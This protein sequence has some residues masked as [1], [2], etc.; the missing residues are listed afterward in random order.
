MGR[1]GRVSGRA[2]GPLVAALVVFALTLGGLGPAAGAQG[3]SSAWTPLG[4]AGTMASGA[5]SLLSANGSLYVGTDGAGVWS[6]DG[7]G[8]QSLGGLTGQDATVTAL[9]SSGSSLWAG[10]EAGRVWSWD[11]TTW[12]SLVGLRNAQDC[13]AVNVEAVTAVTSFNGNVYAGTDGSGLFAWNP[14]FSGTCSHQL[15][16]GSA[17]NWAPALSF[18]KEAGVAALA[19]SSSDLYAGGTTGIWSLPA[20]G[21]TWSQLPLPSGLA[22]SQFVVDSLAYAGST[23]YAGTSKSGVWTW[24][25]TAW[26]ELGSLTGYV[27]ALA[28]SNGQLFATAVGTG[29]DVWAWTGSTWTEVGS[30]VGS[31]YGVTTSVTTPPLVGTSSALYVGTATGV[32][33]LASPSSPSSGSPVLTALSQPAVPPGGT[34]VLSGSGFGASPGTVVFQ[35]GTNPPVDVVGSTSGWSDTSVT[36]AV[37]TT[38][39]PEGQAIAVSV[40]NAASGLAS[41]TLP[42]AIAQP[43]AS[44]DSLSLSPHPIATAGSLSPGQSVTVTA[45]ATDSSGDPVP[46]AEMYASFAQAGGGG[47]AVVSLGGDPLASGPIPV[48]ANAQGKVAFVYTAPP[49]PAAGTDTLTVASDATSSPAVSASDSYS[50]AWAQLAG[51]SGSAV[52]VNALFP[53]GSTLYAGTEDGVWAWDGSAWSAV[54]T[55]PSGG[56]V[57][58]VTGAGG[59][60]YAATLYG[61]GS[62]SEVWQWSAGQASWSELGSLGSELP[63]AAKIT[64]LLAQDGTLYAATTDGVWE[65]SLSS[66]PAGWAQV[67]AL[68]GTALAVTSLAAVGG[69][70]YAGTADQVYALSAGAWQT[71]GDLAATNAMGAAASHVLTLAAVNGA[72]TAGTDDGIWTLAGGSWSQQPLDICSVYTN[73]CEPVAAI[74]PWG[75]WVAVDVVNAGVWAW[76]GSAWSELTAGPSTYQMAGEQLT[77]LAVGENGTLYA[78]AS[79]PSPSQAA[80]GVYQWGTA[81]TA[82]G[83]T[84]PP[85][86][87]SILSST[88]PPAVANV[89]Y[90]VELPAE[91]GT[92]PYTW[93]LANAA[94]LPAG[95]TLSAGGLLSGTPTSAG[96]YS[97][98]VQVTDSATS[99]AT[100]TAN[101]SLDVLAEPEVPMPDLPPPS[102]TQGPGLTVAAT[103][104]VVPTGA[105]TLL[106]AELVGANGPVSGASVTFTTTGGTLS[107]ASA[108][109]DA[110]G[111]ARVFL[112]DSTAESDTVTAASGSQSGSARITFKTFAAPT[113]PLS[114]RFAATTLPD[115][116][117]AVSLSATPDGTDVVV[118]PPQGA[119]SFLSALRLMLGDLAG[120]SPQTAASDVTATVDA[121][122]AVESLLATAAD[123]AIATATSAELGAATFVGPVVA[124]QTQNAALASSVFNDQSTQTS[125]ALQV[126]LPFDAAALPAGATPQVVWLDTSTTPQTWTNV[127]VVTLGV[128]N[129]AGTVTALLPHLSTYTV[130]ATQ[131]VAITTASLPSGTVGAAYDASLAAQGGTAPYTWSLASGS[132]PPGL[133]LSAAGVLSGTPSAA[134]TYS[135]NVA[136]KDS[137]SPPESA[138]ATLV[139]TV[140]NRAAPGP[141]ATPTPPPSPAVPPQTATSAY[142]TVGPAGGA[143]LTTGDGTASL[144]VPQG[145]FAAQTQVTVDELAPSALPASLPSGIAPAGTAVRV[146]FGQ[147]G[148]VASAPLALTLNEQPSALPAPED[149]YDLEVLRLTNVGA[150]SVW[151]GV[152]TS[153]D[154][155]AQTVTAPVFIAGV[156]AVGAIARSAAVALPEG[157]VAPNVAQGRTQSVWVTVTNVAGERESLRLVAAGLASV[158]GPAYGAVRF[159]SVRPGTVTL[160]PGASA[161][162][163]LRYAAGPKAAA[164]TYTVYLETVVSG[165][166]AHGLAGVSR[167]AVAVAVTAPA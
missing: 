31:N 77:A 29:G 121:T 151:L 136:V 150:K 98:G 164:G 161:R 87:L 123:V 74:V 80:S 6:W 43:L 90:A 127:G 149:L 36:V 99:P 160:P 59:T 78:A 84:T 130:V 46:Y 138:S 102:V 116:A 60:L 33:T 126:T 11:G 42:I 18:T 72:L 69:T 146:T 39:L 64:S 143:T 32:L 68:S 71:V 132:L 65:T 49:A 52:F 61:G 166:V 145:A 120:L 63:P 41:N 147:S 57:T 159:A 100:A 91:G 13:A 67:G 109:T 26:S 37:P 75:Q 163:L 108:T 89:P 92:A 117:N 115:V 51:L 5:L 56:G 152:P 119:P 2:R 155:R 73:P 4:G 21:T 142:A 34:L 110:D 40:E 12:T 55:G 94:S 154:A 85:A 53:L 148:A 27:T 20:N 35:Q 114:G 133:A 167:T 16:V 76:D 112:S 45:S 131:P 1:L 15:G 54:G 3:G 95:L 101:L 62:G 111:V 122:S 7:S 58:A 82:T 157:E 48:V 135:L 107:A 118:S 50:S 106:T 105:A 139:L 153:V 83:A 66:T 156:Y 28:F 79:V 30:L 23:L 70:V 22:A 14:T 128:N 125:D 47:A 97:F 10:T 158:T 103:P 17:G 134:G 129:S 86:S 88:L 25:G 81:G 8:W 165:R 9:G 141:T 140:T 19:V 162:V 124:F 93:S 38:G 24:N 44:S 137:S 144:S 96:S 113:T 104:D